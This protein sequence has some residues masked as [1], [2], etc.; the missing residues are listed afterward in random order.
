MSCDYGVLLFYTGEEVQSGTITIKLQYYV[1]GFP[2]TVIDDSYPLCDEIKCP[3]VAGENS[4]TFSNE[5]PS[6]AP[7]VCDGQWK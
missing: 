3:L 2:V 7:P 6:T 4:V 1:L 5:V